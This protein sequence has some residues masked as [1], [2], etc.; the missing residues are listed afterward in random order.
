MVRI[1]DHA[2]G[3]LCLFGALLLTWSPMTQ[4]ET[5][6]PN[7][8]LSISPTT[9]ILVPFN[10]WDCSGQELG[11]ATGDGIVGGAD[12]S[13]MSAGWMTS[14]GDPAYN[15]CADFNR[16]GT[17]DLVDLTI[18]A[19]NW[20]TTG[21]PLCAYETCPPP[22][23]T[24]GDGSCDPN[25]ESCTCTDDCGLPPLTE[26]N[27]ANGFD[28]DCD[29]SIDCDDTDCTGALACPL[30]CGDPAAGDCFSPNGS[31]GCEDAACCDLVCDADS[32][33][34]ETEWDSVCAGQAF[35]LCPEPPVC[36]DPSAGN[37]FLDN[38]TPG[39]DDAACC[40]AV[41]AIDPFCCDTEWDI[42]CAGETF[43]SCLFY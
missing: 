15:C 32:F 13:A 25:E 23:G 41:C 28:D 5:L 19:Q 10:C 31:I 18:D 9:P 8:G 33:C 1:E 11:D 37:C 12:F 29:G 14:T 35:G 4:A 34:C 38:G 7:L 16:D 22:P 43:E 40:E 27:C 42:N 26:T 39:C 2:V 36:G 30:A 21:L 24:C 17:I 20:T 6:A 3:F